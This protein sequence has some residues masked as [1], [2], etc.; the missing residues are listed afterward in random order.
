MINKSILNLIFI[1]CISFTPV[2]SSQKIL[3]I[4]GD[5]QSG[6][7]GYPL[8]EDFIVQVKSDADIPLGGI[9][10]IFN[11]MQP[12]KKQFIKK[13]I[14][15]SLSSVAALTDSGGFARTRLNLGCSDKNEVIVTAS[16]R[17]TIGNPVIF[18]ANIHSKNWFAIIILGICGGLG[19]F[20][21]GMFYLNESLQKITGNKFREVLIKL[22]GSPLKGASSGLFVT[23]FN[24]SSSATTLLEVSLVSAGLLTFYQSMA[25]TIGA[26]VGS[27]I[28]A[29][30]VAFKLSEYAVFI[31]GIG[32]FI[33][34][35][36]KNKKVKYTGDA[37]LGFGMLFLGMKIMAD[38]L[39]PMSVHE[40]F[41]IMMKS[42]ESPFLAILAGMIFTMM[43]HSSGATSG[44]V[45][46][47]ALAGAI[48]LSQAVPLNLGAQIGTCITS[49]LGAIGR[50][51]E[52]KRVALWHVFHQIAGVV[53]VFPF[54]IWIYYKGEPSWLYFIKWVTSNIF[55]T[56]DLARQIAMSHTIA[57]IFNA[58]IFFP[59]LPLMN[60]F[61]CYIYPPVEHEKPFGPMYI[62]EEFLATP[63]LAFEQARK[64]II[65]EGGI[66]LEMMS[67]CVKAFKAKDLKL[68]ELISLKDIRVDILRNEI[69]PYLTK[70]GQNSV[71]TEKESKEEIKLLYIAADLEGI[72]D[73]ID[74]NIMPMVRKKIENRLWFSDEGLHD[75]S[76][77][78]LRVTANLRNAVAALKDDNIEQA[79][80]V[81]ATKTDI[82]NYESDLRKRHISRLH[83]GLQETLET[84]SVHIDLIDQFKRINSLTSSIGNAILG[85]I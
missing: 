5:A 80:L 26:E 18:S 28:T 63:S 74:K 64:E 65:R 45:V 82:N 38:L 17:E 11:I 53:L 24:Q 67:D 73:I 39:I 56:K 41:I 22:T 79:R 8:K 20:L 35:F 7:E 23:L 71:L 78:H 52:G 6:I 55:F 72:G 42:I 85:Q 10:V 48:T 46:A 29:Q 14:E 4:S 34:F 50:G 33:S 43:I 30:L 58:L 40:P 3:K 21:F 84:S 66:V 77:L 2:F 37:I 81:A 36:A 76:D 69:I 47:L 32:F 16:T 61:L 51:R 59:F 44:I 13:D 75:I 68:C 70:I 54:L 83:S 31:A 27:T 12:D 9:P 15:H 19:I 57:S 25:V 60:K 49:A 1:V 62:H